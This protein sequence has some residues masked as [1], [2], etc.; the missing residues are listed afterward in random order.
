[1]ARK[2][3]L[4]DMF[5]FWFPIKSSASQ[6]HIPNLILPTQNLCQTISKLEEIYGERGVYNDN[7]QSILQQ[8]LFIDCIRNVL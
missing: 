6:H 2:S 4:R 3:L 7:E 8:Q 1:M 5:S